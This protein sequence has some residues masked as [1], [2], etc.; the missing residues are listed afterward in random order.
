MATWFLP[1]ISRPKTGKKK[2]KK[3]EGIIQGHKKR[4]KKR[5]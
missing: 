1:T 3:K 5:G 4:G 2:K